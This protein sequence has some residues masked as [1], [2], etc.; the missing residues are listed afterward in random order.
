M[1]IYVKIG[2]KILKNPNIIRPHVKTKD[3]SELNFKK[4]KEMG[5]EK[6]IFDKGNTLTHYLEPEFISEKIKNSFQEAVNVFG[7]QNIIICTHLDFYEYNSYLNV[8]DSILYD[9][10]IRFFRKNKP[11]Y[12]PFYFG[13]L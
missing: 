13:Y 5:M 2:K 10:E 12:K 4:M 6:I 7:K 11:K 3:I 1:S 9:K 8:S